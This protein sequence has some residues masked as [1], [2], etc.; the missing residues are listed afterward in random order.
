M[1]VLLAAGTTTASSSD[2]TLT[3]ETSTLFLDCATAQIQDV[4]VSIEVKAASGVYHIIGE[5]TDEYP[6][7]VLIGPGTYRVTR[8]ACTIAVGVDRV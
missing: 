7:Q 4:I 1:A 3:G 6:I 8:Q 2:F 5:L